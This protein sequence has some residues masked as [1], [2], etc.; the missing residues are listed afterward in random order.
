META[1]YEGS[2][3][4]K[5][6]KTKIRSLTGGQ[7]DTVLA[8]RT[9]ANSLL[10]FDVAEDLL[11]NDLK[12]NQLGHHI[13]Q[14][15]QVNDCKFPHDKFL[16]IPTREI[17]A[18]LVMTTK[19]YPARDDFRAYC[20]DE[21][22]LRHLCG[23]CLHR[24]F[25]PWLMDVRQNL[26]REQVIPAIDKDI[27]DIILPYP[28]SY[29]V[30]LLILGDVS[31]FTGSL[32]NS[33]LMLFCMALE[34]GQ[35][36]L[37]E[38][39]PNLYSVKGALFSA[40]WKELLIVYLYLNVGYPAFVQ[41]M[42]EY[43][44]L[45]GGFLGVAANITVGLTY[46][47]LVLQNLINLLKGTCRVVKAQAGGDDFAFGLIVKNDDKGLT[48]Q[49]IKDHMLQYVG[50]LKEF[51]IIE[52][53]KSR[54]GK[55][56][57]LTFCRKPIT[58]NALPTCLHALGKDNPPVLRDL[59]PNSTLDVELVQERWLSY[60][61]V[62]TKWET[63]HGHTPQMDSMRFAF[64]SKYPSVLPLRRRVVEYTVPASLSIITQGTRYL[65]K[66]LST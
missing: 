18:D 57:S 58:I 53:D 11:T 13:A 49:L 21:N 47:A 25:M 4:D 38:K 35:G 12:E 64:S 60:D 14:F 32:G 2:I 54:P 52:L 23:I 15:L 46:L 5:A 40:T 41:E 22:A 56:D 24:L 19:Y 37:W 6:L 20:R 62:L 50:H 51:H 39:L 17:V 16:T 1:S 10:G 31:N 43:Q 65:T 55:L 45:P 44:Q 48:V 61:Q 28:R 33:W 3:M 42:D 9:L 36:G 34:L 59:L 29:E 66:E 27:L 26:E 8:F 7:F 30:A 63:Q